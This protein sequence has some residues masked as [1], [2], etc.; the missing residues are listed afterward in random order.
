MSAEDIYIAK[1]IAY[2]DKDLDDFPGIIASGAFDHELAS[3][4]VGNIYEVGLNLPEDVGYD[5]LKDRHRF[6]MQDNGLPFDDASTDKRARKGRIG[7]IKR[8]LSHAKDYA[9]GRWADF[10]KRDSER[11]GR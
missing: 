11:N 4:L 5:E 9:G 2:R 8:R 10:G 7:D 1:L 3:A 6:I